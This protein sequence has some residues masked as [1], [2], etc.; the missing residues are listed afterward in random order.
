MISDCL[1]Q[2]WMHKRE[3]KYSQQQRQ[4]THALLCKSNSKHWLHAVKKH[5]KEMFGSGWN[6]RLL[7]LCLLNFKN[8]SWGFSLTRNV[9]G[10]LYGSSNRAMGPSKSRD[11]RRAHHSWIS[12]CQWFF[13]QILEDGAT[14]M[15][16]IEAM[17]K[18]FRLLR[19]VWRQIYDQVKE[20]LQIFT[21]RTCLQC[22][23]IFIDYPGEPGI[24]WFSFISSLY[25]NALGHSSTL[26]PASILKHVLSDFLATHYWRK[27]N[28]TTFC[29]EPAQ[30][31]S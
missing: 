24:F 30:N 18:E 4:I 6:N 17:K 11:S 19:I 8:W 3:Q 15:K 29:L 31:F 22:S 2:L 21:D 1:S 9:Y 28:E 16:L 7:L 10:C 5:G 13:C 12:N 27:M 14:H 23:N 26:P 25:C 20:L